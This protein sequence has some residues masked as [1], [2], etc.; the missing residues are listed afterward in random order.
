MNY[1]RSRR[2][3]LAIM[4]GAPVYLIPSVHAAEE[5]SISQPTK[6]ESAMLTPQAKEKKQKDSATKDNKEVQKLPIK[7]V[8]NSMYYSDKTGFVKAN[9][10]V[11]ITQG[12]D[13]IKTELV[14]GNVKE[15]LF[16]APGEAHYTTPGADLKGYNATYDSLAKSMTID[17]MEGWMRPFYVRGKEGSYKQGIGH[18]K[19]GMATTEHAMAWE[20]TPD[21]RVTGSDIT[22]IPNDKMVVKEAKF[23]IKNWHILTL[24]SYTASLRHDDNS[25]SSFSFI[26]RPTYSSDNGFGLRANIAYPIVS[27]GELYFNYEW[28]TKAG[29]KPNFG[30]R[31]GTSWG[32]VGYLLYGKQESIIDNKNVWIK[33]KNEVTINSNTYHVGKTP[34]TIRGEAS[35]GNWIQGNVTGTHEMYKVELSRDP[36]TI[37]TRLALHGAIGYQRDFYHTNDTIRSMPYW[38]VGADYKATDRLGLWTS[39]NQY[40]KGND[41]LSPYTFDRFTTPKE[42]NIGFN[43]QIDRLNAIGFQL[44]EDLENNYLK[45]RYF[46]YHR[47]LHSFT[48]DL[49]Y[50]QKEGSWN[51]LFTPKDLHF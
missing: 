28:Y 24:K 35:A 14:Q 44:T 20:H 50:E 40:N 2:I 26:P 9:G 1:T 22:I 42:G 51:I 12:L 32:N 39:Y 7:V 27:K 37:G 15:N 29:F 31:Q 4:L 41:F 49:Q 38:R 23:Y 13:R 6:T 16:N 25:F 45:Y 11:D 33:K 46:R 43:Y 18:I 5:A 36:V 19:E 3:L 21:Y 8:A 47:D 10:D 48:L 30:Y 34:Y 17:A